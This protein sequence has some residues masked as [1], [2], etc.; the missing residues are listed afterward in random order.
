MI[1]TGSE[2]LTKDGDRLTCVSFLSPLSVSFSLL[3]TLFFSS[4]GDRWRGAPGPGPGRLIIDQKE[5]DGSRGGEDIEE[6]WRSGRNLRNVCFHSRDGGGR[7]HQ[8]GSH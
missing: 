8:G 5:K 1:Y 4:N 7:G 2:E 6:R 3:L